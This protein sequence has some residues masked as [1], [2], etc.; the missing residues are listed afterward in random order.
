MYAIEVGDY[1]LPDIITRL[2]VPPALRDRWT[3][4]IV[5]RFVAKIFLDMLTSRVIPLTA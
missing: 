4:A 3:T 1:I 2:F 5:A